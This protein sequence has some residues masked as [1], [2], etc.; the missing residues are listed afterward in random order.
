[1]SQAI[2]IPNLDPPLDFFSPIKEMGEGLPR[3]EAAGMVRLG[4]ARSRYVDDRH[5]L[6]WHSC[7]GCDGPS[8]DTDRCVAS[9]VDD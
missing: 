7:I 2:G 4:S 6:W 5:D 9:I 8:E 3:H 1:M